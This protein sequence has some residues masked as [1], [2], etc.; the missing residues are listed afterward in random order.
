VLQTVKETSALP[1]SR[2]GED[3]KT[4]TRSSAQ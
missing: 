3:R 2:C 1:L 4:K